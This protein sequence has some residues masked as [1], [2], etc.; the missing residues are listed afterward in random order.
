MD[1]CRREFTIDYDLIEKS[2]QKRERE[3]ED[4][5]SHER[6]YKKKLPSEYS[7]LHVDFDPASRRTKIT[8]IERVRY[9]TIER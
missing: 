8:F 5:F 7:L 2:K 9:R 1:D 6:Y 3:Y 4:L